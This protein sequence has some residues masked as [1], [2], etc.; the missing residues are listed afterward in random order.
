MK[1]KKYLVL[2]LA[3]PFLL[4]SCEK[5]ENETPE[6]KITGHYVLNYGSYSSSVGSLSYIDLENSTVQNEIYK[7]VNGVDMS[8]KP[9]YAYE[10]QG[11][12]Y[13]MG[14]AVDEIYFVEASSLE[15]TSNGVSTDIIKPRFCVGEGNYLY[16]SCWGGDVW[17]DTSLGYI[18][19]YNVTTNEVEK[20]IDMPGGPEGLVIANGTLFCALNYDTK[21][22][23]IDLETEEV[24]F[25]EGVPGVSSYFLKD[26]EGNLFVSIPDTYSISATTAGLGY[27]NTTTKTLEATYELSSITSNYSSI[28]SFNK[29]KSKIYVVGGSYDS[30]YNYSGGIYVFDTELKSFESEPLLTG[31]SG[32]NGVYFNKQTELVYVMVSQSTT[33]NGLLSFYNT[34]GELQEEFST[35]IAPSWILDVE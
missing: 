15:Q 22:G 2:F 12:I 30:F 3:L 4:A 29:D 18:A 5:E 13:F 16:I 9:Q 27:I 8:G 10:Y 26:D 1:M 7:A 24:S 25:I 11:D 6:A 35:G 19:K 17:G 23:M 31:V 21:I 34:N 14:N 28:M 20:T 33:A 32:I